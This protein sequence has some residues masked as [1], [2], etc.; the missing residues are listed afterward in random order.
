MKVNVLG[1]MM[2]A[3]NKTYAGYRVYDRCG[4]SPTIAASGF[5]RDIYVIAQKRT[6]ENHGQTT[7][8]VECKYN[9]T[10]SGEQTKTMCL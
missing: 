7:A 1:N 3:D 4:C 6:K 8:F 2:D 10:L 9:C 5:K